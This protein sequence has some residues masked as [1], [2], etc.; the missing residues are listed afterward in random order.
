MS[1]LMHS[2]AGMRPHRSRRT[3]LDVARHIDRVLQKHGPM[4]RRDLFNA[5]N[6][7]RLSPS[8]FAGALFSLE[9][10]RRIATYERPSLSGRVSLWVEPLPSD[11]AAPAPPGTRTAPLSEYERLREVTRLQARLTVLESEIARLK[12]VTQPLICRPGAGQWNGVEDAVGDGEKDRA[13]E[14]GAPDTTLDVP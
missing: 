9:R 4:R 8:I 2:R 5:V 13:A 10:D 12:E 1:K 6:A 14:R 11:P 3:W 7:R